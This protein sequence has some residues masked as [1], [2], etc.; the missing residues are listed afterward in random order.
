MLPRELW[1]SNLAKRGVELLDPQRFSFRCLRC[2]QVYL[3]W[4]LPGGR[5]KRGYWK[6]PNGC[7]NHSD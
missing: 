5:V 4:F 2:G 6:C 7:S 3:T 1:K